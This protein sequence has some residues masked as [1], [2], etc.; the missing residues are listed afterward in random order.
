MIHGGKT[1]WVYVHDRETGKLIRRSDA[2]VPHENLFT[3][4]TEEGIRMLPGANGGVEWSPAPS[5]PT[6]AWST[7]STC[8]SR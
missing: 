6:P 3:Q 1:G 7:T 4:P 2:M 8:T 5:T